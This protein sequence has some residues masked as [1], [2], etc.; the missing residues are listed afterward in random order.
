MNLDIPLG[1]DHCKNPG[2]AMNISKDTYD[3][4][5]KKKNIVLIALTYYFKAI[6]K[7]F[8]CILCLEKSPH[9]FL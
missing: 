4:D 2:C 6:V 5:E 9:Q 7:K 3:I 8:L 1:L